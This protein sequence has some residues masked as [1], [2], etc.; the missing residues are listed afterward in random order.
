MQWKVIDRKR[1]LMAETE[2]VSTG[3]EKSGDVPGPPPL[4]MSSPARTA[5]CKHGCGFKNTSI[6]V[7]DHE[8]QLGCQ[9]GR[10]LF[11]PK[12][13]TYVEKRSCSRGMRPCQERDSR[14]WHKDF[15]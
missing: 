6:E 9:K 8:T 14:P 7:Y 10:D 3:V 4:M 13:G 1:L 2:M 15:R 5:T 11:L 12:G